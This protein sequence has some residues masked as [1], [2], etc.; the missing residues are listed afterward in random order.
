MEIILSMITALLFAFYGIISAYFVFENK[1]LISRKLATAILIYSVLFYAIIFIMNTTFS[2][3]FLCI[4][5]IPFLKVLFERDLLKTIALSLIIYLIRLFVKSIFLV[6]NLNMWDAV[7][8]FY[9]YNLIKFS[10]NF[11]ALLVGII[12]IF[13]F[14]KNIRAFIDKIFSNKYIYLYLF[15]LFIINIS[16]TIFFRFPY[17]DFDC[18]TFIDIFIIL[19]LIG[20]FMF[21][22]DKEFK[23]NL[24]IKY[25]NEIFEYAKLNDDL[26]LEYRRRVHENKNQ[27]LL[28]KSMVKEKKFKDLEKYVNRLLDNHK[29]DI[30]NCW[31]CD[32]QHIQTPGIRNFLNYKLIEL[33][34]LGATIEIFI[35]NELDNVC[36]KTDFVDLSTILGVVLD[37][38]I[39]ALKNQN[40]KLVSINVY[41]DD[42]YIIGEF[43][44]NFEGNIDLDKI[45]EN[46]YSSKGGQHGV[47]LSLVHDIVEKNNSLDCKTSIL[48]NFFVQRVSVKIND[49]SKNH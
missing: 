44:N 17:M 45:Y 40:K 42:G 37:N 39:E 9:S 22:V 36:Q 7:F 16:F 30:K 23:Y 34:N 14:R 43:V 19:L 12:I 31:L 26:N 21:S 5:Y 1:K 41:L 49:D 25:Y 35:S 47:G 32:L 46:G 18:T 28:I 27:L 6:F 11:I 29:E 8:S 10:V 24:V 3:F 48:D 15:I 20:S 13:F 2:I 38:M 33:K 4:I